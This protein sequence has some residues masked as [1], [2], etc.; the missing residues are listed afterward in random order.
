[1]ISDVECL[2]MCLL[3]ICISSLEKCLFSFSAHVLIKVSVFVSVES[4]NRKYVVTDKSKF[5]KH[6]LISLRFVLV[7]IQVFAFSHMWSHIIW[8]YVYEISRIGKAVDT[9]QMGIWQ[10]L[11][12]LLENGKQLLNGYEVFFLRWLKHLGNRDGGCITLWIYFIPLNC[13][14]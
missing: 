5:I 9:G 6:I 14:I 13:L 7:L 11:D 4:F 12:V 1:M 10:G 8:F 3:A 2:F